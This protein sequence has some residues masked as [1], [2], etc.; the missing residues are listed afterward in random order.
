VRIYVEAPTAEQARSIALQTIEQ[1]Q[2]H[3]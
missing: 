3:D 2:N 1:L